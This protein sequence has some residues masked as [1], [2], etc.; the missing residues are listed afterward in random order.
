MNA[1][2]TILAALAALAF[3]GIISAKP[4]R[5]QA[6]ELA[7][8]IANG[9]SREICETVFGE[10]AHDAVSTGIAQ[11]HLDSARIRQLADSTKAIAA[12]LVAEARLLALTP[13]RISLAEG[14]RLASD[15][16]AP[17][18]VWI[19]GVPLAER[20]LAAAEAGLRCIVAVGDGDR[21]AIRTAMGDV[22]EANRELSTYHEGGDDGFPSAGCRVEN[23]RISR[24]VGGGYWHIKGRMGSWVRGEFAKV[25][26]TLQSA[27]GSWIDSGTEYLEP[28][29]AFEIMIEASAGRPAKITADSCS[30]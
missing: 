28:N 9:T 25:H 15:G 16:L 8:C 7:A 19:H 24:S 21:A 27:S 17:G 18:A 13:G 3:T 1:R 4:A 30:N 23:M 6:D 5:A 29:G 22:R 10:T 14:C 2:T 12:E 26:Y 11:N 20:M